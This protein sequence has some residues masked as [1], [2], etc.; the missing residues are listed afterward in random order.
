[1]LKLPLT[2]YMRQ[3]ITKVN[4]EIDIFN[5]LYEVFYFPKDAVIHEA[6]GVEMRRFIMRVAR[7]LAVTA[8]GGRC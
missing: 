8:P 7:R 2:I 1:M 3:F 5:K 6:N 4:L